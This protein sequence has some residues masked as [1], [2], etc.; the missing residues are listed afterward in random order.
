VENSSTDSLQ[1]ESEKNENV[2][3]IERDFVIE[4]KFYQKYVHTV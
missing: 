1:Y 2:I 4:N 3:K